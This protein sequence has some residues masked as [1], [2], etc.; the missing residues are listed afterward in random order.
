[1]SIFGIDADLQD[2]EAVRERMRRVPDH[3]DR[4]VAE[5]AQDGLQETR[6]VVGI[7]V[8]RGLVEEQDARTVD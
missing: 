2:G 4:A 7:E 5:D 3:Q 6:F 1:M 8:R